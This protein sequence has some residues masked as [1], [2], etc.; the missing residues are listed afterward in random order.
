MINSDDYIISDSCDSCGCR[1]KG[2]LFHTNGT[3]HAFL[4]SMCAPECFEAVGREEVARYLAGA[5]T[6]VM[7][8]LYP[9]A[10]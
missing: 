7:H 5:E 10:A 8:I 4:C 9:Q 6:T 3:P 2:V 1:A